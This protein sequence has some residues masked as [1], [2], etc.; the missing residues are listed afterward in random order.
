M[1]IGNKSVDS[2][3][4]SFIIAEIGIN[5]NGDIALAKKLISIAAKIKADAVKFQSFIPEELYSSTACPEGIE[6]LNKYKLTFEQQQELFHFAQSKNI[7]FL[8]TP[9]ELK[10]AKMLY[11]LPVA[12]FKIGSG[13]INYYEFIEYIAKFDKP[14]IISTGGSNLSDVERAKAAVFST[15]NT[16]VVIMHC[17]SSYPAK[18]EHLNLN[19]ITTLKQAFPDC[20]IGYSDHS[21]GIEAPI[22]ATVL[23]AKVIEKHFTLNK[24]MKGPDHKASADP[25]EFTQMVS[26][27]RRTEL[28]L[29]SGIKERQP[30]E[31]RYTRSLI[32]TKD[33]KEG[34]IIQ[35]EDVIASRPSG[36]LDPDMKYLFL[37]RKALRDINKDELLNFDMI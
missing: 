33:I 30:N 34:E 18:D 3:S 2:N 4:P 20:I 7:L 9:F 5:H 23:G 16:N 29:G 8:S 37:G 26:A 28:M 27:I 17:V 13:E 35:D 19:A 36:G 21:V 32:A 14:I 25:L 24:D 12:A 1:Q 6:L 31:G 11:E 15:G 22:I 10:S